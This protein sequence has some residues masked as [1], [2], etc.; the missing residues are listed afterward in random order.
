MAKKVPTGRDAPS[1]S[2]GNEPAAV[3]VAPTKPAL[4]S[5][6][7]DVKLMAQVAS[8]NVTAMNTVA[9]RLSGRVRRLCRVIVRNDALAD[10]AAQVALVEILQSARTYGGRSSLERWADR[11][12]ARVTLRHAKDERR[13]ARLVDSLDDG[14]SIEP[15]SAPQDSAG[16]ARAETPRALEEYLGELP[17]VQRDALVMK[18]SL[19]YTVEEIAEQTGVPVGTVKDRLVTARR[20]VRR[21]IQRDLAT[22]RKRTQVV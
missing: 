19:G 14:E 11:I 15:V 9:L 8:G 5:W 21:S 16:E 10:D 7:E 13:R 17:R 3:P 4:P 6:E 20:N 18:H 12:T 2:T 22:G 1:H